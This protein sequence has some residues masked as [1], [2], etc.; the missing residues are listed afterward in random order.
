MRALIQAYEIIHRIVLIIHSMLLPQDLNLLPMVSNPNNKLYCGVLLVNVPLV[1]TFLHL[2]SRIFIYN[3][4]T[5]YFC[6]KNK[7]KKYMYIFITS[8]NNCKG[9]I[10]FN[11]LKSTKACATLLKN[12]IRVDS[13]NRYNS[14]NNV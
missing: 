14:C 12:C 13:V 1:E 6:I 2:E 5:N 4:I 3:Q 7:F 10:G 11:S 8:N 9:A